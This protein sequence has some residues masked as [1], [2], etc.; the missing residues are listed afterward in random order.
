[1]PFL[2]IITVHLNDFDGLLRTLHSLASTVES[3]DLEWIVIDGASDRQ[4]DRG[5]LMDQ[6]FQQ[7]SEFV[8]EPDKGIYDAMNKGTR[9]ATGDYVLYLNA[10][11]EL[12]PEF[13]VGILHQETAGVNPDMVWGRCEVHYPD[14]V[15]IIVRPR[16]KSMTW[17]GLPANHQAMFF[18]RSVLGHAP[19]DARFRLAGDYELVCRL[20]KQGASLVRLDLVV[21]VFRR[22]GRTDTQGDISKA[23]ENAI[24]N[25]YFNLHPFLGHAIF[26]FKD[27]NSKHSTMARFFR[28]WR[29]WI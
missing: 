29:R 26:K 25:K 12:H 16:P 13:D 10:G 8:S 5:N 18:R 3:P 9:M 2:S 19:Y 28:I 22:G 24:R 11:D 4:L 21:S 6:V 15:K 17:Y 1:M 7:A 14:G 23:E 27:M 20:L